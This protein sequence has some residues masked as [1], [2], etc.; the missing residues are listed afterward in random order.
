MNKQAVFFLKNKD[1]VPFRIV[2][3]VYG[4]V[5]GK[6][7]SPVDVAC[8]D[9]PLREWIGQVI[10]IDHLIVVAVHQKISVVHF[11]QVSGDA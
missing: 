6:G 9:M 2:N 4:A 3:Q 11:G 5:A 10:V 1:A 8:H 7:V